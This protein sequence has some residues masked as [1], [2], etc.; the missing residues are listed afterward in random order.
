MQDKITRREVIIRQVAEIKAGL[1]DALGRVSELTE[2]LS[3]SI[4]IM[5]DVIQDLMFDKDR[6]LDAIFNPSD[7]PAELKKELETLP[8]GNQP[9]QTA[10]GG[11]LRQAQPE[12]PEMLAR[13]ERRERAREPLSEP[14]RQPEPARTPQ[15]EPEQDTP[16]QP[17]KVKATTIVEKVVQPDEKTTERQ[18]ERQETIAKLEEELRRLQKK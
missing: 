9:E 12:Q 5:D 11:R 1:A 8:F 18:R 15:R 6:D 17:A 13:P 16:A 7:M 2:T 14:E 4:I 10:R 3:N